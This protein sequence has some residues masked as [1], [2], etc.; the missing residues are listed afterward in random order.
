MSRAL[1]VVLAGILFA[2]CGPK[3]RPIHIPPVQPNPSQWRTHGNTHHWTPPSGH[4]CSLCPE[5]R[6]P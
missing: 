4:Y 5:G 3:N 2:A 1:A 6:R